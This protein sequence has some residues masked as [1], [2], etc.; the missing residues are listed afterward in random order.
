MI[1]TTDYGRYE[2]DPIPG[3][4]Q[5]AHC[6]G[7]FVRRLARGQGNGHRLKLHQAQSLRDFHFD[8]ATCTVSADNAAQI[9]VLGAAGWRR[10]STFR[11]GKTLDFVELWGWVVTS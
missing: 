11:S 9:K 4:P 10:L 2:I 1:F 3:Q 7:F 8:Y 6:H 5:A